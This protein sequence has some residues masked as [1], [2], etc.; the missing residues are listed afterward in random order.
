M[1][2]Y[3]DPNKDYSKAI[4]EAKAAGKDTSKLEAERQNKID[5]KYGGK[6]PNMWGSD[7]TYSQASRDDDR[8]TISNA[9]SISNSK[10]YDSSG[11]YYG[12][13]TT[14]NKTG[15]V[16]VKYDNGVNYAQE[17]INAAARGD[18]GAVATALAQR[19]A[20]IAASGG[21]DRGLSNSQLL[22]QLQHETRLAASA[23]TPH[24]P[25]SV[26]LRLAK[27]LAPLVAQLVGLLLHRKQLAHAYRS[28]HIV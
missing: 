10:G 26:P 9:I 27:R 28:F 22:A 2:G 12:G 15:T 17:A 18:W 19:N 1:A 11:N 13:S 4:S 23:S 14:S 20:K 6:E 7:K 3:Y 16:N 24:E 8:D 25:H 21:N 5:D